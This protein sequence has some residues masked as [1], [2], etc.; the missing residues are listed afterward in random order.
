MSYSD[1]FDTSARITSGNMGEVAMKAKRINGGEE[2][3]AYVVWTIKNVEDPLRV[4]YMLDQ[5][6]DKY[7]ANNYQG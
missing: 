1:V 3:L 5:A 7:K 4:K 2:Y 6:I